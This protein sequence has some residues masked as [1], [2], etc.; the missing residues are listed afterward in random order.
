MS[1]QQTS[2]RPQRSEGGDRPERSERKFTPRRG[3]GGKRRKVCY[4]TANKITHIDY[5]DI[6]TLKKFISERGKILPRRVTGT[7]AKYQRMLTTAIKRSRTIALLPYTT[8]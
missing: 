2:S 4:F 7:S 8:E 1:E 6:E 3:K 5:K